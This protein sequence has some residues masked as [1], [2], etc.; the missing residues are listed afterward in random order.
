MDPKKLRYFVVTAAE[1]SLH[2][3]STKLHIAQPALSRHIRSLE[4]EVGTS[5]FIRS[6]QGVT[7][8]AAGEVLLADAKRL[9]PQ[10]ELAKETA[11][12]AGLGQFGVLRVGFTT[13]AAGM[14]FAISAFAA[15]ARKNPDVDY[16]LSLITSEAQVDALQRGDIDV[17]LLYRRAPLP[18]NMRYRD[19]R[20]DKHV[21]AVPS[22]HR[23][24]RLRKVKLADL[25]GERLLFMSRS[26]W[27]ATYN[28]L[29]AACVRGGLSPNIVLELPGESEGMAMNLVAEGFVLAIFNRAM[30]IYPSPDGVTFLTV[31]DLNIA[32]HLAVMW[33]SD[34]ENAAIHGFV[35]LLIEHMNRTKCT[36]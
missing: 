2:R 21:V 26:T 33:N 30:S 3:A 1:G 32:L 14:R 10:I 25:E 13:V 19:L 35:D 20:V 11:R 15:A 18:A 24:T 9:L 5:L 22:G 31:E 27:P 8:S 36:N 4:H 17:G 16:R 6:A 28:E 34:R 7:L 12:R 29:M 23:L